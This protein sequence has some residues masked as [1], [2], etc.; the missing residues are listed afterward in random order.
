[1]KIAELTKA[2]N[3]LNTQIQKILE[4]S[5]YNAEMDFIPDELDNCDYSSLTPDECQLITSY[6][7][8]LSEFYGISDRIS[9]LAKPVKYKTKIYLHDNGRYGC[10]YYEFTS[11]NIIEYFRYDDYL[12]CYCWQVGRI[13]SDCKTGHYYICGDRKTNL[14]GLLVR[15]RF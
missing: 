6:S 3:N 10:D 11:G 9:Y 12:E 1:M 5:G 8:I 2:I 14:D 7:L 15:F 13:E 4:D